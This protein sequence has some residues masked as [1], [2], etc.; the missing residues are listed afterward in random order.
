MR[1]DSKLFEKIKV[2]FNRPYMIKAILTTRCP[3]CRRLFSFPTIEHQNTKYQDKY[4]NY[5]CGCKECVEENDRYWDEMWEDY[6][7]SIL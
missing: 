4:S 7:K 2:A 1:Y 3:R 6:Y 5:F